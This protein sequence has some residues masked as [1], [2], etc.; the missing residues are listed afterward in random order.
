MD[1]FTTNNPNAKPASAAQQKQ[2]DLLLGR[3]RQLMAENGEEWIGTLEA[4]P[5]QGA[6]ALGTNTVRELVDMSE[7]AGQ[8]VDPAVLFNVGVQF[9]K[10]IAGVVN[11]AGLV[12][13]EQLPQYLKDVMSQ[14][15]MEY[16]SADAK[17]GKIDKKKAD[18]L[19]AKMQQGGGAA[20][21]A[22]A[23]APVAT[24]EEMPEEMPAEQ[25]E[26]GNADDPAMA[27]ELARIRAQRTGG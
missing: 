16:L 2:F 3:A 5:V 9:V 10:D 12:P 27:D 17:D 11:A 19:L 14:S 21:P 25:P 23:A 8:Q 22:G 1:G 15:M 13:D 18:G 4:D 20:A 24:P 6:V 7:Q 26:E